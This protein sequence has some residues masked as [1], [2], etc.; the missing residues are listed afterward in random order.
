MKFRTLA[1]DGIDNF[2]DSCQANG[3]GVAQDRSVILNHNPDLK[4]IAIGSLRRT[5]SMTMRDPGIGAMRMG[6]TWS[7]QYRIY[8]RYATRY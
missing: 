6:R 7:C 5:F 8:H 4:L 2:S 3:E 1:A